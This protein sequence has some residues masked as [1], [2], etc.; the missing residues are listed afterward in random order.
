M[1]LVC[2]NDLASK[3]KWAGLIH[4]SFVVRYHHTSVQDVVSRYFPD[5][6]I[7]PPVPSVEVNPAN[8][9]IELLSRSGGTII[10]A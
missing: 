2:K 6:K 8:T 5:P 7:P 9:P 10:D 3:L 4:F 1:T